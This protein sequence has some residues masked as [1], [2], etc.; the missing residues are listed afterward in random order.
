MKIISEIAVHLVRW[1]GLTINSCLT[2]K[3]KP[4]SRVKMSAERLK[5]QCLHDSK[6]CFVVAAIQP[7]TDEVVGHVF[8][9]RFYYAPGQG[10]LQQLWMNSFLFAALSFAA[11]EH[12][13]KRRAPES[14][15]VF[16]YLCKRLLLTT[17]REELNPRSDQSTK[18]GFVWLVSNVSQLTARHSWS[19]V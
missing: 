10:G 9:S 1:S 17:L 19:N 11:W 6:R 15:F 2:G 7:D 4:G 12:S 3:V 5:N 13:L 16:L 8:Y 14:R 18:C